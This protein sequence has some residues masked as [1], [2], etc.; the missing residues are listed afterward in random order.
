MS[1]MTSTGLLVSVSANTPA[2]FDAT[3]FA[4]LTYTA[5]GGVTGVS[6]FGASAAMVESNPLAT[7]ETE[8]YKGFINWGSVTIDSDYD[9]ADA[10]QLIMQNAVEDNS[11]GGAAF[12]AVSVKLTYQTG[13]VRYLY[14]KVFSAPENP[15]SANSMV[16]RSITLELDRRPV[17][18]AA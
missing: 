6:A 8:K 3:G 16:T 18:V 1:K 7:G 17:R 14:G 10:G 9:P 4:A 2:S 13:D 5:L 15:G 11:T 12:R